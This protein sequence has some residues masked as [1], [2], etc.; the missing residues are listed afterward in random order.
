MRAHLR[1]K[2]LRCSAPQV[3]V[4]VILLLAVLMVYQV[5][6]SGPHASKLPIHKALANQ[7]RDDLNETQR[8]AAV[9]WG[10]NATTR[11][12]DHV[13]YPSGLDTHRCPDLGFADTFVPFGVYCK[14][15]PGV[16]ATC[17]D[18]SSYAY[19]TFVSSKE[20]VP[21]AAT[22]MFSVA[23]SGS[24]FARAFCVTKDI[25]EGDLA[26]LRLIGDIIVIE[27]I[28]SPHRIALDRYRNTFTKLRIWQLTMYRKIL[29][30]DSDVIVTRNMDHLFDLEEWG[31]PMDAD[32]NRYSTGMM[33]CEPNLDTFDAMMKALAITKTSMEFPDLFFLQAFFDDPKQS[34]KIHL[35]PRWY[36]VYNEEFHGK[37]FRGYLTNENRPLTIYD[38]RVHGIH[39]PGDDKPWHTYAADA[40]KFQPYLCR[41]RQEVESLRSEPNFYWFVNHELMIAAVGRLRCG[42]S[43]FDHQRREPIVLE[44]WVAQQREIEISRMRRMCAAIGVV[45]IVL[46]AVVALR[47][48]RVRSALR[49]LRSSD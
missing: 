23:A 42:S 12:L 41:W 24:S 17:G 34:K 22:L 13:R 5:I 9:R 26:T 21:A 16:P 11:H 39:Y 46:G 43:L 15:G 45:G 36:Q 27:N 10:A 30:F 8:H 48:P 6:F 2:T 31:V 18:R 47:L 28:E 49:Q 25:S 4:V 38:S 3:A 14:G 19:V 32:Q 29:Y 37:L 35:I 33:L 20:F 40:V 44:W 7:S 1:R